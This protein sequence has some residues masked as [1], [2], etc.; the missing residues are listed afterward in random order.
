MSSDKA[1]PQALVHVSPAELARAG[2]RSL[3]ARG[4]AD[5]RRREEA[6]EWL[7]KG[8]RA[9][10]SAPPDPYFGLAD[11]LQTTIPA[12]LRQVVT[13]VPPGVAAKNLGMTPEDREMAHV[14][15]FLMPGTLWRCAREPKAT[16]HTVPSP[17]RMDYGILNRATMQRSVKIA[18]ELDK[19][20]QHEEQKLGLLKARETALR[21][22][23]R[24]F[25]EGYR[26]DPTNC[27]LLYRLG[28]SY[29]LGEGVPED[30]N[31]AVEMFR[32]AALMGHARSQT[33]MGDAHSQIGFGCLP[34]DDAQAAKWYEAAAEQGDEEA[35]Q[36]I[37]SCYQG[38]I[39]VKQDHVAAA[40]LLRQ[41]ANR[42]NENAKH[43]LKVYFE[44]FGVPYGDVDSSSR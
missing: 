17:G 42:G 33:A 22:A 34:K 19:P 35:L 14:A 37:V 1:T 36:M 29:R 11:K 43:N 24:C 20:A 25:E 13:G 5:L 21:E 12:Y 38:G 8:L 18:F 27:E 30:E 28:E 31:K 39:G 2:A 10:E 7:G 40:R 41:S 9:L 6:E 4:R 15:H 44:T 32:R 26:F 23:F 3:T 16:A